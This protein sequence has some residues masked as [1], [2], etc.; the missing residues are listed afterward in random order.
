M[1]EQA[2]FA[3]PYRMQSLLGR[4]SWSAD[5]LR[6]VVRDYVFGALGD[7]DGVLVVDE[8]GFLKKGA[9]SVGVARQYSGTAGRIENSQVGGFLASPHDPR[10]GR[11]PFSPSWPRTS[12]D[13]LSAKR[14]KG[15]Q[16]TLQPLEPDR[17]PDPVRAGNPH[18]SRPSPPAALSRQTLRLRLVPLATKSSSPRRRSPLQA[19]AQTSNAT[20]VLVRLAVSHPT[21]NNLVPMWRA[22]HRLPN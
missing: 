2:G 11:P 17:C 22:A 6:G 21:G 12:G 4:S 15:V 20:V 16:R 13:R 5:A 8:T 1:A 14:T 19:T 10:H 3:G 7:P 18:P 9:R